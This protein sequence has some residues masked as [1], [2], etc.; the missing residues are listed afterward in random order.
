MHLR[1]LLRHELRHKNLKP[2]QIS[3][4]SRRS[5]LLL[6]NLLHPPPALTLVVH[7][8]SNTSTDLRMVNQQYHTGYFI[9]W[10]RHPF[11]VLSRIL[12]ESLSYCHRSSR[13]TELI[14]LRE[15]DGSIHLIPYHC[16]CTPISPLYPTFG[17][18][19]PF[20]AERSPDWV[21]VTFV[22]ADEDI[23]VEGPPTGRSR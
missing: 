13:W 21:R 10:Q 11:R 12:T 22:T 8:S 5:R 7:A 17:A 2:L 19:P 4:M 9:H 16:T 18:P 6:C 1:R 14:H 3:K 23:L 20:T 15:L